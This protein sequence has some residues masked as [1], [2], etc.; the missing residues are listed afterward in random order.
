MAALNRLPCALMLQYRSRSLSTHRTYEYGT[1]EGGLD[2]SDVKFGK[3]IWAAVPFHN[4]SITPSELIELIGSCFLKGLSAF[5][6]V[7]STTWFAPDR[8]LFWRSD[9]VPCGDVMYFSNT[10]ID[11]LHFRSF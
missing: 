4:P 6:C 5:R 7:D 1:T 11:D 3:A 2:L 9:E 8:D 10:R